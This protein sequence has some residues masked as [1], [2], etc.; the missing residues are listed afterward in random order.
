MMFGRFTQRAQKVLALSQEEAMRL[1]HSNLGTE[2]IL[3]GLV[4]EGEGIAA[5]ALYELGISS[6]KVQQEVEGLIGHG[7]KA[8]TT[9]QYT[10]RA[11]KVIEL[12]MDEARK[13]GHTYVG[14]E[15]ILLG[16]IREGEG[17]AARVL[18]NLG[19]SLNKARQQV[20]QLLGGGD[21]TGA[22]RQT[23]TQATPTLDSLA[24]DLTVIAREDNLDPVIGR[25]KEIQRV[26]EVLSRRTKNNPV[27]I[28][29][30]GVGKTAIA[31]GLAQQ[32]VRNEVPETLRG[33]RVMTLDMGTVVAGTKY[34]GEF[35]DRLKKVMDEI[36]Q[37]GNVILFIDELHTLIGAGGAEGAIDASNILKP[38]LARGELQCIGATTLDEYRKYIEKDAALERRFQPIKV[39]EPTVEESIQILHGLRDRYEAHHR[40]AI[41]DEALE[42]A[43]R[44]SDRYISDRFLPDKAIDV[45]DE[46]GSKVRLKSFT[47]P[48][49]VKEMENNLSDLKKEKDA[50]VQGQEFEKAASLRDKEQKLK[51]SLEETKA[52]WQEKQGLDHSEV[53]ED[54]VAEVVASWTGIPVAKLAETETNK[55]LN[56]E[57]LLH[58][59]VIGQDAAV[60]AVSLAVRRARAGLKDPK[61]PIGSFIF[62]GPTGVGKTELARALAESMFGDEDS[63]IRIDMSEYMEKFS[64]ARL[65]GAPP[66]Y[67]GYEEGGQLTEKVRQKPYS[68]VLLD[69]IEKAHPDVFNMLLQV[70]DDGRLTDSKGRV[71]D[72]RNTVIIMT[73]NIGAQEM[74]QDKS[75][76]FN[77]TDPLKDHKAMEHRVLQDLKQAFRPE[78]INRIDETIVFHSLQEKELKQIVTLLTTQLTK[79]LAERDIHVKLTEGAKSKIAKDGYDPEYGARPL[80]RAIQK[81]VEDMLSEELLR[82]NIKVGDYVEIGVKDG[83]LEVRK[84]DAPKK[85]TTSKKVKAK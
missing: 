63:M 46:S 44:L 71:V 66:G 56:M 85:K 48:K 84:K 38:P 65:V 18:S 68:V 12:S 80:K 61:R 31:E 75:M 1:N 14:T 52:N 10:P 54:I 41:T 39:D 53:T 2:H 77:V 69:E 42:A 11:K 78:F 34:R 25:S 17:V 21:A 32:I 8:V 22:G 23:N 37:A 67:V 62:L 45:I 55:L 9:I 16:L 30:P 73:S 74:K 81:E 13:L 51:K 64:T 5:K 36:R 83:K 79:R 6:E 70:L 24:R 47:T 49:N 72:F 40:V 58:E 29:E 57:K 27:L 43:V 19:I 33:K 76:G 3:L 4:R 20:L 82:G 59:R 15:H 50:A 26:I 60:K 35:E 28:G 7:E